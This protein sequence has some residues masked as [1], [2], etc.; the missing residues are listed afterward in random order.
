M[1]CIYILRDVYTHMCVYIY[2]YIYIY[3]CVCIYINMYIYIYIYIKT[4]FKLPRLSSKMLNLTNRANIF[5]MDI[6]NSN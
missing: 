6:N 3:I 5:V 2:I 1:K 4:R